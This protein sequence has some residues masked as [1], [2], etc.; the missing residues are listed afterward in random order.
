MNA[1]KTIG[2]FGGCFV[3][4]IAGHMIINSFMG[5]SQPRRYTNTEQA[6]P[7]Q[8]FTASPPPSVGGVEGLKNQKL[9]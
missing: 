9:T 8:N 7:T 1:L 6:M 2:L 4:I 5:G 3:G